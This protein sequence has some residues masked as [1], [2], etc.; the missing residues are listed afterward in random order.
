MKFQFD[1]E[2]RIL[3]RPRDLTADELDL[4]A[5]SIEHGTTKV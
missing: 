2:G 3:C 4:Y 1:H 5:G